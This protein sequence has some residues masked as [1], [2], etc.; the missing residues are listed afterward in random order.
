[1]TAAHTDDKPM[2]SM[3]PA[4]MDKMPWA[5]FHWMVI[6]GLG[7]AWILD[8]LEVQIVAA[9]GFEKSLHMTPADVGLAATVYLIGEVVGALTFGRMTDSLGRK[10]LFVLTLFVY[11]IGSAL[12]AL[13]PNA[14]IF[15][16]CRFISGA[17]IGGEY[18]AVNS[19]IDELIP[20][21][22]RGR[23][24]LAING[25]YWFG[26]M[27]GAVASAWLLDTSRFDQNIGWRIAFFLGPILG[28]GII[29]LRRHIPESPRWMLTH[30]RGKE[31]EEIVA[32]IEEDIRSQ[33]KELPRIHEDDGMWIKAR[34]GLTPKQLRYV[35]FTMYPS[36]TFLGATLMITQSF[37]YNAIFFT[38]SL[39]LQ[40]FYGLSAA[41]A[42][43][44]FFPFAIGNLLGP[45]LLGPLFDTVGRRKMI[46]GCYAFAGIVLAVSAW[47]FQA[48]MLS[49]WTHTAFWC[50]AFF[51]A[52]AGASAGY[53][54]VSEIFPLEVRG[55]AIS[56][57]FAIAQVFGSL[58][59]VFY[60]WLIGD[61]KDR[62]PMFW[63]YIIASAI[64]LLGGLVAMKWGVDAEGKSL[65]EIAPPLTSYDE[66]GNEST[67]LPV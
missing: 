11:L 8:G 9:G 50:V 49:A 22:F 66:H 43:V 42:A 32:G 35:F 63:G 40:N 61:G 37:L 48:N 56:Y 33:G 57:F 53:L 64:M 6:F 5:R 30:G 10:K 27:L 62:G 31:A 58:G 19:A 54:T 2:L 23:V 41:N 28:L 26:A 65:E 13:A 29:Y 36:R 12:A 51:F 25:T 4:R 17:G 20:G 44:Y 16:V 15:Y 52:S 47:M 24:D 38:Y 59:P 34:E 3:I 18:S 60:G 46:F 67:R 45:L 21:K 39:V 7:T 14:I 1:M 55:Q